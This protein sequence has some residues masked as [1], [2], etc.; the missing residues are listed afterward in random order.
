VLRCS[1]IHEGNKIF[2]F[3]F[4]PESNLCV[5]SDDE[6]NLRIWDKNNL[7]IIKKINLGDSTYCPFLLPITSNLILCSDVDCYL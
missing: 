6:N 7:E 1:N 2:Y 5:S 4:I 3:D